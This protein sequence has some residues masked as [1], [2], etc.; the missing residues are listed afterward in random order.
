MASSVAAD[1]RASTGTAESSVHSNEV[2]TADF[3]SAGLP[4]RSRSGVVWAAAG[5]L[6]VTALTG[7]FFSRSETSAVEPLNSGTSLVLDTPKAHPELSG[8]TA[9]EHERTPEE[10]VR[11]RV[12]HDS[13][14]PGWHW[15]IKPQALEAHNPGDIKFVRLAFVKPEGDAPAGPRPWRMEPDQL[16]VPIS[17]E[18]D[19]TYQLVAFDSKGERTDI[20]IK[21]RDPNSF[22][23]F[24]TRVPDVQWIG[25][26]AGNPEQL[27]KISKGA[28]EQAKDLGISVLPV[29]KIGEPFEFSLTDVNGKT[30]TNRDFAGKAVVMLEW[31]TWC[32]ACHG[33]MRELFPML[34]KL[35]DKVQ[36]V[37]INH[38]QKKEGGSD[39]GTVRALKEMKTFPP[40]T[41]NVA[42]FSLVGSNGQAPSDME[43]LWALARKGVNSYGIPTVVIVGRDGTLVMDDTS[44]SAKR[45]EAKLTEAV[46]SEP[47]AALSQSAQNQ[48]R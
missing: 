29:G 34:E 30:I 44:P 37:L 19:A 35:G 26:Q 23:F 18:A 31:A 22:G 2:S 47:Q 7:S 20:N 41:I 12:L 11:D 39:D 1:D 14:S 45:L 27:A 13:P 8:L 28:F 5:L 16:V 9:P 48:G 25:F 3:Q 36:L 4:T 15:A 32:A 24:V 43:S 46:Q 38:N 10:I 21:T 6:S 42:L 40:G 17:R 33:T